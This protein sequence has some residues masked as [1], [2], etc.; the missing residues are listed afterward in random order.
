MAFSPLVDF[1]SLFLFVFGL[2]LLVLF[3]LVLIGFILFGFLLFFAWFY[4][5]LV[6]GFIFWFVWLV[7]FG[8][9]GVVRLCGFR[10]YVITERFEKPPI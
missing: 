4:L 10:L 9:S 2:F 1:S 7:L 6:F 3:W 5:K 8:E